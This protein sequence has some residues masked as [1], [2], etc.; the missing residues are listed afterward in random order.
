MHLAN[1][2]KAR[3]V[4]LPGYNLPALIAPITSYKDDERPPTADT[5]GMLMQPPKGGATPL[6]RNTMC[7]Q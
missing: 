6:G 5:Q 2:D 1:V 3:V 4:G 7:G